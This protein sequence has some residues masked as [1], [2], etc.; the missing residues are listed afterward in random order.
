MLARVYQCAVFGQMCI[1]RHA[2][3]GMQD[4]DEIGAAGIVGIVQPLSLIHI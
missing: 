2:A 3:I 1:Q 4:T